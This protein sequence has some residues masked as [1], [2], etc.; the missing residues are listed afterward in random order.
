MVEVDDLASKLS[1]VSALRILLVTVSLGASLLLGTTEEHASW[2]YTLIIT[3]YA[4]SIAYA[5]GLRYRVAVRA[6]AIVQVVIDSI[7]ASALVL[8]TGGVDSVFV[9]AYVFVVIGAAMTLFRRGTILA[10]LGCLAIFGV[11]SLVQST[12]GISYLPEATAERAMLSMLSNSIALSLVGVLASTLAENLRSAGARLAQRESDFERL[13]RLHAAILKS[14]PAGLMTVDDTGA[15]RYANESARAILK[16]SPDQLLGSPLESIVPGVSEAWSRLQGPPNARERFETAHHRPD[17]ALIRIGFSFAP[18]GMSDVG[19]AVIV[20]FQDLTDIAKLKEA[21]ERAERLAAVGN[22]A[23]G[24][25]HEIRNPLAS[26]C[27]SIHVLRGALAPPE[28]LAQLMENVFREADRLNNLIT[29][30][31]AFARPRPIAPR[32]L[33]LGQL[34]GSVVDVFETGL[35]PNRSFT[36]ERHFEPSLVVPVDA[37]AIRQVL[38]NLLRNAAQA[39]PTGGRVRVRTRRGHETA[40]IVIEDDGAGIPQDQLRSIFEPFFTT[41]AGGTGLGL[42]IAQSI[43]AAHHGRILVSSSERGTE[44]VVQLPMTPLTPLSIPAVAPVV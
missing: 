6:F 24:L 5:L 33:D 21:V 17:G 12:P 19:G 31:L 30:F 39:V 11:I 20:V 7:L 15:I 14:L 38:W 41:K 36:V 13:E 42:P 2:Q 4:V 22:L 18:L 23:S 29:D 9:F 25:A 16:R 8:M 43:V 10:V 37:D 3:A 1:I 26:M 27:A 28:H 40:E 44:F 32:D 35:D 34:V